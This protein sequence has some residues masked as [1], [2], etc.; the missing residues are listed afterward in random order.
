MAKTLVGLVLGTICMA[1]AGQ[2]PERKPDVFLADL[3]NDSELPLGSDR[4]TVGECASSPSAGCPCVYNVDKPCCI[5]V[6]SGLAC[7]PPFG[8]DPASWR[9]FSDCGCME[10]PGWP[11]YSVCPKTQ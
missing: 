2:T 8:P 7:F 6:G 5:G 9:K 1:C 3:A 4:E 11:L 10:C